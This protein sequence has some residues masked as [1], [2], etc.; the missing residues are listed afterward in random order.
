M[1]EDPGPLKKFIQRS[2]TKGEIPF[3]VAVH[4][5]NPY[6]F[7][8]L[9]KKLVCIECHSRERKVDKVMGHNGKVKDI[10]IFYGVGSEKPHKH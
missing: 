1:I 7:K 8:P 9:L 2:D 5:E 10:P 4:P 6:T 3:F